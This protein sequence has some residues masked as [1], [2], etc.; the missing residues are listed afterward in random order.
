MNLNPCT[1]PVAVGGPLARIYTG[2]SQDKTVSSMA[3]EATSHSSCDLQIQSLAYQECW[4]P[5]P[6]FQGNACGFVLLSCTQLY[7]KRY[8]FPACF[9]HVF[10]FGVVKVRTQAGPSAWYCICAQ[11]ISQ[12]LS[13]AVPRPTRWEAKLVISPP[14]LLQQPRSGKGRLSRAYRH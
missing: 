1:C 13:L 12:V 2:H 6:Q 10:R 7:T 9:I 5:F 8:F 14:Q 11:Q 3:S 4:G